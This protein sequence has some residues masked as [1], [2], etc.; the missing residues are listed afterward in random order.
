MVLTLHVRDGKYPEVVENLKM[1]KR[2]V[3]RAGGT[4]HVMRQVA[5]PAPQSLSTVAE[6]P[7][8]NALAKAR[9]DPDMVRLQE[10]V[11]TAASPSADALATLIL[12]DVA[13]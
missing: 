8:W 12:E 10:R 6:Y 5:G 9:S 7:D 13:I 3:E 1:A 2:V 11:R 4:F